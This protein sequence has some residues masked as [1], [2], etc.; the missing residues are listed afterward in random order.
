MPALGA[1]VD[2][3]IGGLDY[4]EMMLNKYYRVPGIHEA[5]QGLQQALDVRQVQPGGRLIQD[6][7]AYAA[8]AGAG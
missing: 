2:H 7:N 5:V 4:I 1:E 6:I 8:R 3:V